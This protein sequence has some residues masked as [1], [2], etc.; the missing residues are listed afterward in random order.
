[1]KFFHSHRN[2]LTA[3]LAIIILGGLFAYSKLQTALF[4]EITFPKIKIIADAGLQ[5]VDKMMVTVTKPL[6]IAIKQ[7]PDLQAVRSTTSRGSCEIS[8]FMN[9]GADIDLAQQ[10]IESR[11]AHI[12]N[13]LP[14]DVQLSVERMNPSILP[15]MGYTLESHGRTPIEMRQLASFTIKPFLSQVDGVSEVRVIGGRQKE[16]WITLDQQ[17][18]STLGLTPDSIGAALAQTNFIKSNGYLSDYRL[19]YLTV[20]DASVHTTDDLNN[21]V[22][23]NDGR[24]I[25]RIADIAAVG[26][27]EATEY[28]RINANG[29][30]GLLIAVIKQP[31]ANLVDVSKAME[32]KIDELRKILPPDVT[33]RPYYIQ[34][35]FVANAVRS[36]TDSLLVG[37]LLAIAVAV[38]FLRSV[39]ASATILIT[40]PVTLCLTLI[41]LYTIGYTFNIMTLGAIAA[42]IGLIIDDAIVVVEQIHR[43]HEEHPEEPTKALVHRAIE[44]LFPAMLGSS[45]S[46]IVIFIP[47]LLMT[48]VAGAYFKVLTN[49]MIITLVCS[50]FVTWIGLPV[51]YLLLTRDRPQMQETSKAPVVH[52][53]KKQRWV[54]WF[55][56]RPYV[57]IT[58]VAGLIVCMVLIL[59]NLETGFLPEMDEGSVV[60][61]YSSPPG[62]SLEETDRML[63]ECEKIIVHVPEVETY[64]RRTGT[65]MGF[66]ITEPNRGDYLIQLKKKRR[67]TTDE[68][69]ADIRAKI[70]ASQPAL[71]IDFGQVIGD[72]LGDLMESVQPIEL[73]IFGNDQKKLQQLST[74]VAEV[75]S[76]VK[77]TADVFNGIVIAGP[78]VNITPNY[79]RLAQFGITP[80]SLQFQI[81]TALEGNIVSNILETEQQ[82]AVRIVYPGNRR[83]SVADI[84]K[85]RLSIPGGK[86]QPIT[87][88]ASV[89]I[90][91]GYA[92]IQR[93]NLQSMGVV[94]AR[95]EGSGLG[96]VM[97]EIKASI[98]TRIAL[99]PGYHIEYGGSYAQQQKS[100][101]ELLIILFTAAF[102]V[103]GVIL[104]LYK[105]FRVALLI[106]GLAV[107]GISGS[108]IG[109]F[110]TH[111]PLNV[112][113]YTGLIMIVG[114]IGEN[115]IFT[116]LQ[117]REELHEKSVDE[118][119]IYSISTRLRPKLMTALGAIIALS[120]LALGIGTGA[121]LHQ[122]L[123]IAVIGG[124]IIALPLLLIV[125]PTFLR[126]LFRKH[127]PGG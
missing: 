120:P 36:V 123:A 21:V 34:A 1:M 40:I 114:I 78:S 7:V 103:F 64:S 59:P 44:Y 91:P 69:I 63:R 15:V 104:F 57:S 52:E 33:I 22:I 125:L 111:T 23:H 25:V 80:A 46:T 100:F 106:V 95:L 116:F 81:Q 66:F 9:W 31:N 61:D 93:E 102:L 119:I 62:T 94:T 92:E 68:V 90:N 70:E 12:R 71:R 10:R 30:E 50:F 82:P 19:L 5:P 29:H 118:S 121:Q 126:F 113:S 11:I 85:L 55:I 3:V 86:L 38:I 42:A 2:P 13:T 17:K 32:G 75:V 73:K 41:V 27:H 39:K 109:L 49:T 124:F 127:I 99:P 77:G 76:N 67:R 35:D 97:K 110:L 101:S 122:P 37:L 83:L 54:A 96:S 108:Y 48:G 53:V 47:F 45:I 56:N 14:V 112:G 18:M 84:P 79:A 117:F 58:I 51:I 115:A 65:Q 88:L 107:L 4:P 8:A 43:T 26:V 16:Y 98:A 105:D 28:I 6:E 74:Q 60:L 87:Q 24:R 89:D 72:M 20:T